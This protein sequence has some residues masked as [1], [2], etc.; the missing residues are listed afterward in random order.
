M[1]RSMSVLLVGALTCAA[2]LSATQAPASRALAAI[3]QEL[4]QRQEAG[5]ATV[6]ASAPLD[7][8]LS[9]EAAERAADEARALLTRLETIAAAALTHDEDLTRE[10]L[11]WNARAAIDQVALFWYY[12]P[13]VPSRLT[14][15]LTT[16]SARQF[17]N[18]GDLRDYLAALDRFP[19]TIDAVHAKV[20]GRAARGIILP[21]EQIDR[22][23]SSLEPF[24][25]ASAT[26]PLAVAAERLKGVPSVAA[27]AFQSSVASRIDTLIAP[28]ARALGTTLTELG[29]RAPNAV[30]WA[31]Y[32]GGKDA[33][34]IAVRQLTT[35]DVTPEE[36]HK[37]GLE[38]VADIERQMADLR[39]QMGFSGTKADFHE[40]LR[41]DPRFFVKTPDEVGAA[42][43]AHVRRIEPRV[44]DFFS[45]APE[46]AYGVTRLHPALEPSQTYGFYARP[47]A[48]EPRGR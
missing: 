25:A 1:R 7:P 26:S 2:G 8:S 15:F 43:M 14:T 39:R 40:R 37:L 18:E 32:P 31:Q 29:P 24:V 38:A 6:G 48:A 20:R 30:G 42:L 3:V 33:Y 27:A 23:L 41:R 13:L 11:R 5:R 19:Q 45:R 16:A 17:A 4:D 10:V 36:V 35:L 12:S 44:H 22:T 47:T 21:D 28:A 46:A 34:R 9:L